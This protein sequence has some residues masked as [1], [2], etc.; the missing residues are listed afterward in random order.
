MQAYLQ[1]THMIVLQFFLAVYVTV[2]ERISH[3]KEAKFSF[4]KVCVEFGERI[5]PSLP[6][7]YYYTSA[8]HRFREGELPDFNQSGKSKTKTPIK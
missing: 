3:L 5:D 6:Y 8:H 7:Y 1:I 2:L 4:R